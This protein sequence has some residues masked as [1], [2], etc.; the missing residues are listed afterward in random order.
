[1]NALTLNAPAKINLTLDILGTRADGYHELRTVMQTVDLA[2]TVTVERTEDEG[3]TLSLSDPALPCDRRNTAYAAA[4]VFFAALQ[5]RGGQPFGVR[6]HV[7]KIIPQ[8]AGM[9]GGSAD[10]AAVLRGLNTLAGHPFSPDDLCALGAQVGAD[11]PFCVRGG[12]A[13]ATGIGERLSPV[14]SLPD[15]LFIVVCK[16]PVG[17]STGAAYAA[18]DAALAAVTPSD[19]AGLLAALQAG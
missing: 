11:V 16:P 17:V 9:A 15:N 10:A 2:D 18:V 19:E 6:I 4:E 3:I 8:Q 14:P 12:A 7:T 1:M 5:K 13:L